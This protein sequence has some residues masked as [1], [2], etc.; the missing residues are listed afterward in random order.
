[1]A[2]ICIHLMAHIS[3]HLL[4]GCLA[5]SGAI[6]SLLYEARGH[7]RGAGAAAADAVATERASSSISAAGSAPSEDDCDAEAVVHAGELSD[8]C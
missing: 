1:M 4:T 3:I 7:E 2:C 6:H 8:F 5:Q